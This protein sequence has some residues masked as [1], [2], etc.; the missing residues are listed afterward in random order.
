METFWWLLWVSFSFSWEQ[1]LLRVCFNWA[2]ACNTETLGSLYSHALIIP[3]KSTKSK[4]QV[5]HKQKFKDSQSSTCQISSKI[6]V[7]DFESEVNQRSLVPSSLGITFFTGFLCFYIIKSLMHANIGVIAAWDNKAFSL[8]C[9]GITR[10]H[11]SPSRPRPSMMPT[12]AF[13]NIHEHL[14]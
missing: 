11:R 7:L 8:T 14:I 5:V 3:T 13:I 12:A 10:I 6:R 2:F 4:Y 9:R 1:P